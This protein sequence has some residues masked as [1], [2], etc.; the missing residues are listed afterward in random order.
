MQTVSGG[1]LIDFVGL[2]SQ[3]AA[4]VLLVILFLFLRRLA[5]RRRY[6]LIWGHAWIA[7]CVALLALVVMLFGQ[8][9]PGGVIGRRGW[10]PALLCLIYQIGKL[11]FLVLL[12]VGTLNYMR[13]RP[14]VAFKRSAYLFAALYAIV[15]AI[16][17]PSLT[18]VIFW[19]TLLVVPVMVYCG[20]S[21]LT[22]PASRRNLGSYTTGLSCGAIAA[23]W[24]VS[25]LATSTSVIPPDSATRTVLGLAAGRNSY[26]DL[27]LQMLLAF[28]MI[29]ILL[30]SA[31][32]ETDN[33]RKEL[34]IA[35]ARLLRESFLDTL[36]GTFNRRAFE[37]GT[38]LE[39]AGASFGAIVVFDLD[40]FKEVNDTFGHRSGDR[41]LRH[42]ATV[43]RARL[44]PS[45][46]LYRW[47]GDEFLLVMPR[48]KAADAAPRI[49]AVVR[50]AP[51]LKLS[52]REVSVPVQASIGSADYRSAGDIHAAV[53]RADRAMYAQKR[54][55]KGAAA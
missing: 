8:L 32:R 22:L 53:Q 35:H 28:G 5:A 14:S 29:L 31:W 7:L 19:Q 2:A 52:E 10:G 45:D 44:R 1:A 12:L 36:T 16:R 4:A 30:E 18:A 39:E 55:R 41:L 17:S 3:T 50:D 37:E 48:A 6:F 43:L 13:G 26:P 46:K 25:L 27:L 24:L 40:K 49:E 20:I 23:L 38:G 11:E 9:Q 47:G 33:A 42:F 21:L 54:A 34:E 51:P 15:S